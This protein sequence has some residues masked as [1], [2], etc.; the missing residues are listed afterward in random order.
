MESSSESVS[1]T[2]TVIGEDELDAVPDLLEEDNGDEWRIRN[3]DPVQSFVPF[4]F[5]G[6]VNQGDTSSPI[7]E[8]NNISSGSRAAEVGKSQSQ[9]G[10]PLDEGFDVMEICC[11]CARLTKTCQ[12]QGLK[13][14]GIDWSG[15]KDKPEGRVMWID[16]STA[17]GLQDLIDILKANKNTL[18]VVFMSPPCGTASRAREIRR[19]KPNANGHVID[20]KPLRSDQYPDGLPWLKGIAKEKVAVANSLYHNMVELALWCDKNAVAWC[21]ENPSNSHMWETAPF[22][23]LRSLKWENGMA[24]PYERTQFQSCMH[25]GQRPKKTTMMNA[26]VDL[27]PL[28]VFCDGKCAHKPWGLLRDGQSFAT[29]EER[30]YPQ[31][32]CSRLAKRF[33]LLADRP[34]KRPAEDP[35]DRVASNKQPRR[36]T[37]DL[38][39]SG[40]ATGEKNVGGSSQVGS[41]VALDKLGLP[42]Q[43]HEGEVILT[44][45]EFLNKAKKLVHPFDRPVVVPPKVAAAICRSASLG[46]GALANH[47]STTLKY[48][49]NKASSLQQAEDSLHSKLESGIQEV[50]K[51]KRILLFK[52]MLRD[53]GYDDLG[54]ADLLV[55]GVKIVGTLPKIGIWKPEDRQAKVSIKAALREAMEAKRTVGLTRCSSWSE[56]DDRLVESTLQ[57]VEE[58]HLKGP[59]S[60]EEMDSRIG[61]KI[62]LPARRFPVEQSGK[63]RP[64]DDFSEFGHN[65]AFGSNEKVSLKSLDTVVAYARAWLEATDDSGQVRVH[66]TAGKVWTAWLEESWGRDWSNLVGRVADLKGAYKQLPRHSAHRCFSIVCLRRK[67][68]DVQFF[69]ALSLMFGQTAAVYAFLRFSRAISA[70]ANELLCLTCVEFFDDFTQIEPAATADSAH[71]S[72]ETLLSLLGWQISHGDKRL[73]FSKSFVSLG[74]NLTLPEAGNAEIVLRNKVGRVEAIESAVQAVF[75]SARPFGFKD[76]LSFRGRFAFA[77]GQTFGRVLAP[78]ARVLSQWAAAGKPALP[79][80]ELKLALAHGALHLK[81]AGPRRIKPSRNEAPVLV[82]TDGAC[83]EEGTTVGGVLIAGEVVECFGFKISE[84]QVDQ[85]KTKLLQK[86]VIGQAELYPVLVAKLTWRRYLEGNRVIHFIDNEAARLGLVKAY[87]PV[88]PSLNIIMDALSWDYRH[89]CESWFARVPS[90]SNVSDG[91]SRLDFSEILDNLK[92]VKV[93]PVLP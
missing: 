29:A 91:P 78:V 56:L 59:F 68:G 8:S 42:V 60:Q 5:L 89:E 44:P 26:G 75:D 70:L 11:G 76:A 19:R 35:T 85:W 77:E 65:M 13:S 73:P 21:I 84:A 4:D 87:S 38:L 15:C 27:S 18:K 58:G 71:S 39:E 69:E 66:D 74:V 32:L 3:G 82:F 52:E 1:D 47:R 20:P 51:T 67:N 16:L 46:P 88:L 24:K 92:G 64:I 80:E 54:V 83:E 10:D 72:F 41:P 62:W 2:C 43:D 36:G 22:K 55:T 28:E 6:V 30:R 7:V 61:S 12:K 79:T 63:L 45:L 34:K 48:Y 40:I 33:A 25:G 90:K 17:R 9:V 50:V 37:P 14:V 23:R 93:A 81:T 86:Q 53:I 57:E 31:L 49:E